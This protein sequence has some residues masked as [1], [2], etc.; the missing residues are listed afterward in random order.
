MKL[1]LDDIRDTPDG[2]ARAYTSQQAID[3]LSGGKVE[4]ISL[5]HDLGDSDPGNGY[6][7]ASWIEENA[8]ANGFTPPVIEIHSANPIGRKRIMQVKQSLIRFGFDV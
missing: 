3:I 7:V 1:F 8:I 2:W 5:D 6:S 4:V